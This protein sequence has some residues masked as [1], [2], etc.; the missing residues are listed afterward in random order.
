V[1]HRPQQR[2][3]AREPENGRSPPASCGA[4]LPG[5]IA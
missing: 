3:V 2:P 5:Q 1:R 4:K